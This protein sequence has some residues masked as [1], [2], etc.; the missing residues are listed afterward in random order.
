VSFRKLIRKIRTLRN[1]KSRRVFRKVVPIKAFADEMTLVT[2]KGAAVVCMRLTGVDDECTPDAARESISARLTTAHKLFEECDRFYQYALRHASTPIHHKADYGNPKMQQINDDRHKHI[3]ETAAIGSV[4]LYAAAVRDGKYKGKHETTLMA[5]ERRRV[6]STIQAKANSFLG[7]TSDLFDAEV[8]RKEEA[9]LFLRKLLNFDIAVAES[10]RLKRDTGV[11]SQLV[12]STLDWDAEAQHLR[13]GPRHIRV[14]SLKEAGL[15]QESGLPTKTVPNLLGELLAI[16]CD[17]ILCQQWQRKENPETRME[18]KSQKKHVRDFERHGLIDPE[19][20]DQ[21]TDELMA[22]QSADEALIKLGNV[23]KE[24]E[25]KGG[26]FGKFAYTIVLHGLDNSKLDAAIAQVNKVFGTFDGAMFEETRGA[27]AAYLAI[28]PGNSRFCVREQWLGNRNLAD[29]SLVYAP[30]TGEQTASEL[31]DG[32]EYLALY[33]TRSKTP[34]YWDPFVDGAFGLV[35]VGR[36]GRGKTMNGNF[37]V[38]SAQKYGGHTCILDMGGSYVET[39]KHFGGTVISLRLGTRSFKINPFLIEPHED[40]LQFLFQFFLVLIGKDLSPD[41]GTELYEQ[42][43][44]MYQYDPPERTL[45]TFY[46]NAPKCYKSDLA[47]WVAGGQFGW[48]FDNTED[49]VSLSQMTCIE[50]EGVEDYPQLMEPLTMWVLGRVRA[51]FF[52]PSLTGVFKLINADEVWKYL[53]N[54]RVIAWASDMLKTGRKHLIACA[55]WTQSAEDLGEAQR[56]VL[57]NC[58]MSMFLGNPNFDQELYRK[59]FKYNEKEIQI[60]GQLKPRELLLKTPNYSKVLVLNVDRKMYWRF[61]TRPKDRVK[62]ARAIKEYG[63]RAIEIL[64]AGR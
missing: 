57:D 55:L 10:L 6:C 1:R 23:L 5:A 49:T 7:E 28:I 42:I 59:L 43:V 3:R 16:D 45:G 11:D 9:F 60:G 62:R 34:F 14:L 15:K 52:D 38:S 40:N 36:R 20:S 58:E 35:G 24:I 56:L 48:C 50:F 63:D 37:I 51:K 61:T 22:D 27:L 64:A 26:Y 21:K 8:L 54:P 31:A 13:A 17:I 4:E 33:E 47:K 29:L 19:A 12:G 53:Q 41:R 18:V 46:E 25:N 39:V 32:E 44:S 30:Y 2:D